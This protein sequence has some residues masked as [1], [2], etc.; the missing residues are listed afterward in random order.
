MK[1]LVNLGLEPKFEGTKRKFIYKSTG[2]PVDISI[3]GEVRIKLL[4]NL[5]ILYFVQYPGDRSVGPITFPSVEISRQSID[6]IDVISLPKL[7][8]L[9]LASQQSLPISRR[10]DRSD[11]IELI[12]ILNLSRSFSDLLHPSIRN[13]FQNLIIDLEKEAEKGSI[14]NE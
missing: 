2:T 3:E 6:N 7:I 4:S 1:K 8:D 12:K 5:S 11:V 13:A 9:K 14:D 10:K